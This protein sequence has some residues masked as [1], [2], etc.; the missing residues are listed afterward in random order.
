MKKSTILFAFCFVNLHSNAWSSEIIRCEAKSVSSVTI[1]LNS[2]KMQGRSLH[3]I[4]GDFISDMT[5]CAPDGEYTNSYPTG[6]A[7]ISGI[8][9]RWRDVN[10]SGGHTYSSISPTKIIF[11]GG[12][13]SIPDELW[14]FEIDRTSGEGSL[15]IGGKKKNYNYHCKKIKQII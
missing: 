11:S 5:P 13:L 9:K 6:S 14:S 12:F 2:T 1:T 8:V 3:C 4:D 10:Q 7:S 15:L